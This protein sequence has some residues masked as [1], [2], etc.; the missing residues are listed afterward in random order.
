MPIRLSAEAGP[1]SLEAP[2]RPAGRAPRRAGLPYYR[3]D[4]AATFR[5]TAGTGVLVRVRLEGEFAINAGGTLIPP[6]R[7]PGAPAPRP[8]WACRRGS[9]ARWWGQTPSQRLDREP[10]DPYHHRRLQPQPASAGVSRHA[11]GSRRRPWQHSPWPRQSRAH[12]ATWPRA[13]R[14][15]T[16]VTRYD[17]N[18]PDYVAIANVARYRHGNSP[19]ICSCPTPALATGK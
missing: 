14:I 8:P 16:L 19:P 1:R 13:R 10:N 6:I 17:G 18:A 7:F 3:I 15:P 4:W 11:G 12:P 5:V 2:A 9:N